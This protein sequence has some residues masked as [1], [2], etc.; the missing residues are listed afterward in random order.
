MKTSKGIYY[1]TTY[2][3]AKAY[4]VGCGYPT[5]RI[6]DYTMGWAIQWW[7]SGPYVGPDSSPHAP[8]ECRFRTPSTS[9]PS[10]DKPE[11]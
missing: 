2:S 8:P 9:H 1:F 10:H 7:K 6:I 11:E 5:G 4:A 3:A